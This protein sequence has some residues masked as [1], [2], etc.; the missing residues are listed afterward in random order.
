MLALVCNSLQACSLLSPS[1][2]FN[3]FTHSIQLTGTS[4]LTFFMLES[5]SNRHLASFLLC[6]PLQKGLFNIQAMSQAFLFRYTLTFF[7]ILY[8][9]YCLFSLTK[10]KLLGNFVICKCAPGSEKVNIK[11]TECLVWCGLLSARAIDKS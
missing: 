8:V 10:M 9:G 7:G 3:L 1:S 5:F 6:L 4:D 11:F 2:T